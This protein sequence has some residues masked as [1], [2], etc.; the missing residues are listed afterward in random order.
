M[1]LDIH[2]ATVQCCQLMSKKGNFVKRIDAKKLPIIFSELQNRNEWTLVSNTYA[3]EKSFG[4]D[5]TLDLINGALWHID[6]F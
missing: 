4:S 3:E 1:D 2:N 5:G 6:V